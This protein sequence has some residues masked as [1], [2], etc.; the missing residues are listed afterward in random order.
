MSREWFYYDFIV[1]TPRQTEEE[2]NYQNLKVLARSPE[3]A[4]IARTYFHSSFSHINTHRKF[5][6]P[7][8]KHTRSDFFYLAYMSIRR[9][10]EYKLI[11]KEGKTR[12]TFKKNRIYEINGAGEVVEIEN[13]K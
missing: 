9:V 11:K 5:K 3:Y 2:W 6:L 7:T 13:E 8:N 4:V 1:G 12:W 10:V